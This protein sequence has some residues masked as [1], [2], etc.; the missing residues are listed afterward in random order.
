MPAGGST[1]EQALG[2]G[3]LHGGAAVGPAQAMAVAVV[4]HRLVD[5]LLPAAEV[6]GFLHLVGQ[7]LRRVW[8]TSLPPLQP[9]AAKSMHKEIK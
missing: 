7:A 3:R 8:P 4:P 1:G 5:D 9:G 2:A 6:A